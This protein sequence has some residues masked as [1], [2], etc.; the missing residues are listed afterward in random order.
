MARALTVPS[1]T[2]FH[3]MNKYEMM[4]E[5]SERTTHARCILPRRLPLGSR[6]RRPPERGRQRRQRH[7]VPRERDADRLPGALGQGRERLGAVGVRP[8]PRRRHEPQRLPLLGRVG[9]HR[10]GRGRVLRR[11]ARALRGARRRMPRPRPRADR[12]VQ[13]LHVAAL[14]RRARRVARCRG[15]RAVRPVLRRR[16]GSLRR[17]HRAS[18]SPSTSPI[19]PRC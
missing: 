13:P 5:S 3:R 7:L 10:A 8:R 12:D 4:D 18:P 17:P 19:C 15:A 16:D 14:V 11:G 9:A 6:H 2:C 1:E